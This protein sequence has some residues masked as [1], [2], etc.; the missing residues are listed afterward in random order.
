VLHFTH[1]LSLLIILILDC[2]S[3]LVFKIDCLSLRCIKDYRQISI[4]S[5]IRAYLANGVK[6]TVC[7][8]ALTDGLLILMLHDY[9][10]LEPIRMVCALRGHGL[11]NQVAV[12]FLL[13]AV[14]VHR[15][16]LVKVLKEVAV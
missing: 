5:T 13:T 11:V 1:N 16:I 3:L 9:L 10:L 7:P 14:T 6:L 2:L 8:G 4:L 15:G 12:E